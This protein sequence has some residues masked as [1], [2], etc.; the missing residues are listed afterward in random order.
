MWP[1]PLPSQP[2]SPGHCPSA[3]RPPPTRP[4]FSSETSFSQGMN[5]SAPLIFLIN[6]L[7]PASDHLLL[8]SEVPPIC[9]RLSSP[10][11]SKRGPG[12]EGRGRGRKKLNGW[13]GG[14]VC[15]PPDP[16]AGERAFWA[17]RWELGT[18]SG[19]KGPPVHQPSRLH[20]RQEARMAPP[21]V[22]LG[23]LLEATEK[24]RG[25]SE[26]DNAPK[27]RREKSHPVQPAGEKTDMSLGQP[28]VPCLT[29]PSLDRGS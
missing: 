14:S 12:M 3:A 18:A 13:V 27:G 5:N 8:S 29:L 11:R 24:V 26:G 4:L 19:W 15:A 9:P 22:Q 6:G 2:L 17:L 25:G 16:G 10:S 21:G 7:P 1:V 23:G 28:S 20:K